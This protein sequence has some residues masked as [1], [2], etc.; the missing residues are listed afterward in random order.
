M[1]VHGM[2]VAFLLIWIFTPVA[3]MSGTTFTKHPCS[4]KKATM[5]RHIR[6]LKT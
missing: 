2:I 1:Y 5:A 4:L 6:E 3:L